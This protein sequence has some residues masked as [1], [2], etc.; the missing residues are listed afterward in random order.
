MK[1]KGLAAWGLTAGLAVLT[2]CESVTVTPYTSPR[3]IGRVV[4]A[5]TG[6]PLANVQVRRDAATPETGGPPSKGGERLKERTPAR[7]DA[8]GR[9]EL[10]SERA[11]TVFHPGGLN[12]AQL[13]FE[14]P[15]YRRFA[16][17]YT[18][19]TPA[20]NTPSGEPLLNTGDIRL[21][22]R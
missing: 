20:T 14:L 21:Q 1:T 16:T 6:L 10:P 4:A 12:W 3:V 13:S 7:T 9:F 15:G 19:L 5:D 18:I 2:G 17:N 11:L 22:R 8:E